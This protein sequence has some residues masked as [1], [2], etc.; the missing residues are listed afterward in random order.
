MGK[1]Y[2]TKYNDNPSP[3]IYN[4]EAADSL[5]RPKTRAA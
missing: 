4:I 1:K 2:V 5:I 3:G